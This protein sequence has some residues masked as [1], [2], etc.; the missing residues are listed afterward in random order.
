MGAL[1]SEAGISRVN[2]RLFLYSGGSMSTNENKLDFYYVDKKYIRD[3]SNAD[4]KVL[5]VSPQAGKETR[6]FVGI[7]VIMGTKEYCIPLTSPKSKFDTK[8]HEDFIKIPDPK[9][10]NS[11]GAALT[12]GIL[13][14]NNMI[15]ISEMYLQKVD[16]SEKSGIDNTRRM[17]LVK[18]LRWCRDN[19]D[20]IS[21]KANKLYSKV[22]NNPEK[23]RNLVRRCC[24]FKKLERVLERRL[25]P[26]QNQDEQL[27]HCK[28]VINRTNAIL[29][30]NPK[31]KSDFITAKKEF[32]QKQTQAANKEKNIQS[33]NGIKTNPQNKH[34]KR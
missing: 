16:L 5:S 9:K 25:T 18:Q 24:D 8:T 15:P 1:P 32:E 7:V 19:Y 22:I 28:K 13:N 10:K 26:S 2:A 14:I 11:N 12:I 27:E 23:D 34:T 6:P 30:S 31:L 21:R 17:L 4:D 29:N 33:N 3:L 20:L